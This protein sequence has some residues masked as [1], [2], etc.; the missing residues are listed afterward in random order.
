MTTGLLP[1]AARQWLQRRASARGGAACDFGGNVDGDDGEH[2]V[3]AEGQ[4]RGAAAVVQLH[5]TRASHGT[6]RNS[7]SSSTPFTVF[8]TRFT[9]LQR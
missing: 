3:A 8:S 1:A 4:V 6:N 9:F 2:G 5:A 7:S